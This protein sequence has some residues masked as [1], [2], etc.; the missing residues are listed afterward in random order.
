MVQEY[1]KNIFKRTVPDTEEKKLHLFQL[2]IKLDHLT[3]DDSLVC[4]RSNVAHHP[5]YAG[6]VKRVSILNTADQH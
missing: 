6:P 4:A 3:T 5:R 1:Q 2:A